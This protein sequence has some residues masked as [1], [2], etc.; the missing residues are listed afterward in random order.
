LNFYTQQQQL[1]APWDL[2]DKLPVNKEI[3]ALI[4][5]CKRANKMNVFTDRSFLS[6]YEKRSL[7]KSDYLQ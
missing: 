7:N 6:G 4:T 2:V 1:R 3:C 5:E